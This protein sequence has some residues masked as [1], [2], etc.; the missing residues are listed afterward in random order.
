MTRR[1]AARAAVAGL[2]A[3]AAAAST[4]GPSTDAGAQESGGDDGNHLLLVEQTPWVVP[5]GSFALDVRIDDPP[6]GAQLRLTLHAAVRNRSQFLRTLAGSS[7]GTVEFDRTVEL[8]E[9]APDDGVY[10][11]RIA[12][13][14]VTGEEI[15]IRL[16]AGQE[17]VYPVVLELLD[18]DGEIV[19]EVVTHLLRL[20]DPSETEHPL[21]AVVVVPLHAPPAHVGLGEVDPAALAP[22]H[23]T[24]DAL[25]EHP[26]AAVTL[27]PTPESLAAAVEADPAVEQ[28][29]RSLAAGRGVLAQPWVRLDPVAW[30]RAELV[31]EL[32]RQ[33]AAGTA[34]A[35]DILG[36]APT[37]DVAIIPAGGGADAVAA[38]VEAGAAVV[39]VPEADLDVLDESDFP[40]TLTRPFL[41]PTDAGADGDDRQDDDLVEAL[42]VDEALASH[43]GATG[44]SVLDAHRVLA[45]LAFLALDAP[46]SPRTGVVV[47]DDEAAVDPAFLGALLAGLDQ[48]DRE[49][50]APLVTAMTVDEALD[51]TDLAGADG[52]VAE[53]DDE[54]LVRTFA[55]ERRS[56]SVAGLRDALTRS[57][58]AVASYRSVF[59][60]DDALAGEA[61]ELILTAAAASLSDRERDSLLA[62]AVAP[63]E[64]L[65]AGIHAPQQQRVTL[66]A[67]EGK[68]QF[69]VGNDTE[70]DATVVIELRADRLEFPE[71]PD[72]RV[73]V[74]LAPGT[75]QVD[76]D[77]RARSS[78]DVRL[79]LRI[80]SPDGRIELSE[81]ALT[82][83]ATVFSGVGLVLMVAAA[84]FLVVWWTRT[85]IRERGASRRYRHAHAD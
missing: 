32:E 40:V 14:P 3:V 67:R 51:R 16:D 23:V 48:P 9:L 5:G 7:L 44:D 61:D 77:V 39:L 38:A 84:L 43:Y 17:G 76:L 18:D 11:Q 47:L 26:G 85:I 81:S 27:A 68:I 72:R 58:A 15:D 45:D 59:G 37:D 41:V 64:Q 53:D 20:P 78:G 65:Y 80:V 82:V 55:T 79:D 69:T 63:L 34:T 8:D 31:D 52:G 36:V 56:S 49:G 6:P 30:R 1:L 83:R 4:S 24:V 54:V 28:E 42:M 66:T 57:R 2:L 73:E 25:L 46:L 19:D 22:L 71:Y 70:R 29:L 13:G 62:A 12:T 21:A 74:E 75:T 60:E 33:Y 35:G 50:A 10:S